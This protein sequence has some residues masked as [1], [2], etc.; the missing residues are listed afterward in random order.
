MQTQ[1][2]K[3]GR[4]LQWVLIVMAAGMLGLSFVVPASL[5]EGPQA[6]VLHPGH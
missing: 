1:T 6:A 2:K 3:T 5:G 4:K